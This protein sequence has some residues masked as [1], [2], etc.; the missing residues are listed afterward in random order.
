MKKIML[1]IF[2]VVL[3]ASSCSK[4]K[5]EDDITTITI[6]HDKEDAVIEIL[7][8]YTSSLKPAIEV[9]YEKK[10]SL[11]ES[12]KMVGNDKRSAPDLY[13][14]A[15]DKIGVYAQMGILAPITDFLSS[16]KLMQNIP[17][18]VEGGSYKGVQY[19]MPLYFETL[20][21]MFNRKYMHED[22]VP[23]TTDE[24]YAYMEKK[25][26]YG[27]YGFV[28][29]HST[30][31]YAAGWVHGFSASLVGEDGIPLLDTPEMQRALE[32]HRKFVS[33][34]PGETEYATVNTL[35]TEGMA[36]STINGPW[37]IPTVGKA[38]IDVGVSPMPVVDETGIPLSPYCGIQGL[39][40]LKVNS[41]EKKDAITKV[42]ETFLDSRLEIELALAT[43]CAPALEACYKE[44][45][46]ASNE[47]VQAMR[48]TAENA[49]AMPNI[50]E[51]DVLW[52][53][54]G[55]LLT[56]INMRGVEVEMACK[57]AQKKAL[58]L[59]EAMK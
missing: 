50:P 13:L 31:Y 5:T 37:F 42:L 8:R 18:T 28:E 49:V 39:H 51:M 11:T 23:S 22:D 41:E 32:Y 25:T 3:M 55:N 43:G 33:L 15:H 17:L 29:Q 26:K 57:A 16:E 2:L 27:H 34:M 38:G 45:Q 48:L 53:V 12:L 35:F 40:V 19:Q 24:L 44:E 46:I 21:F 14:F 56:D 10:S 20:L 36:H 7:E 47:I 52:S 58:E 59:I 30:P 1:L 4:D 6:W 54:F 9:V